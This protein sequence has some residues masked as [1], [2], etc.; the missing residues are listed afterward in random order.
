MTG[1]GKAK[2]KS[3]Y[4]K[5]W[6]ARMEVENPEYM[7][8]QRAKARER[9]RAK[10]LANKDNPEYIEA[11][12]ERKRLLQ[13]KRRQNAEYRKIE[14]AR[15]AEYMRDPEKKARQAQ[16]MAEWK[17]RNKDHVSS[18]QREWRESN[19]DAVRE[20]QKA[21]SEEY[22]AKESVQAE[23]RRRHL[24]KNYGITPE[25]FNQMWQKQDGKCAICGDAMVP[26]GRKSNAACVDH[27]HET[28]EVRGLLCRACNHGIG[29][30]KDSP[31]VLQSAIKYLTERGFYGKKPL[32]V[33][34][35]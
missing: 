25:C 34:D 27:N 13:A 12:R 14:A 11:E 33:N 3:E 8:Q 5:E 1:V 20:Y 18:Y 9:S 29:N 21:Y 26:R 16:S 28:N 22:R 19:V 30:L 23:T 6:R 7:E 31:L 15:K 2:T 10:Y 24:K 35:L 32:G 4:A 17:K